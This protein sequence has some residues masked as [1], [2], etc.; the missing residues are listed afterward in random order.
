MFLPIRIYIF[1]RLFSILIKHYYRI[2]MTI[3]IW[4]H[5]IIFLAQG[6]HLSPLQ[7]VG[8]IHP[9]PEVVGV[10]AGGAVQ[11]LASVLVGLETGIRRLSVVIQN[12]TNY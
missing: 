3:S 1:D 7:L 6:V 9:G 5:I 4:A 11:F 8:E 10:E 2:I 12:L